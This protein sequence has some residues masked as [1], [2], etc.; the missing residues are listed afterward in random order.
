MFKLIYNPLQSFTYIKH[1]YTDYDYLNVSFHQLLLCHFEFFKKFILHT[2]CSLF[3]IVPIWLKIIY[4]IEVSIHVIDDICYA[5]ELV[6]TQYI[7]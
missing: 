4:E 2:S 7:I 6:F 3:I 1:W 5:C